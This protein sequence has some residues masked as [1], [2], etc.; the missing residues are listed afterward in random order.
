MPMT[1]SAAGRQAIALRE[2]VRLS[3]YKDT[4]GILTIGVGHTSA[5]GPP[6]VTAGMKITMDQCDT[7]LAH[8]LGDCEAA[9]NRAVHTPISQNAFDACVSLA[10]NIGAPGFI[11]SSVVRQ[12]NAGN[13]AEAADDFLMWDRPP[14][15][16]GRRK[17]ERAQFLRP[18]DGTAPSDPG[19]SPESPRGSISWIQTRLNTEGAQPELE[20]DGD[21]GPL[22]IAAI[23]AFQASH[24]LTVDGIA[25]PKTQAALAL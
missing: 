25:G 15:L 8:D 22:T 5:A 20:V 19:T 2:G 24:G 13:M 10:F 3:A 18:D 23:K 4:R 9:V 21:L 12:I 16:L 14:E 6:P 11:G 17:G 1:T 7:I